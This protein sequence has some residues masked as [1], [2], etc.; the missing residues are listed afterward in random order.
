MLVSKMYQLA[1]FKLP[2]KVSKVEI[3]LS[4]YLPDTRGQLKLYA[5]SASIIAT[6]F[7]NFQIKFW[8]FVYD[9]INIVKKE[10]Y[11]CFKMMLP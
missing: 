5:A 2:L 3:W 9:I 7:S 10:P 1:S 6:N 11:I 4:Q 8:G